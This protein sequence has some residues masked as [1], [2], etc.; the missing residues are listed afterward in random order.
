M[1]VAIINTEEILI[2]FSSVCNFPLTRLGFDGTAIHFAICLTA[3]IFPTDSHTF[4]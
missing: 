4:F 1:D 2:L 3:V